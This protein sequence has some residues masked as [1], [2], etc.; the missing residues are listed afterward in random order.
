MSIS[1]RAFLAALGVG[2]V[3]AGAAA[4][5]DAKPASGETPE[6]LG[7]RKQA[8]AAPNPMGVT[9]QSFQRKFGEGLKVVDFPTFVKTQVGVS[10]VSWSGPLMGET[11]A[12]SIAALRA[13]MDDAGVRSVL[14]DPALG[15][16]L[17]SADGV[18]RASVVE[19]L[20][21][22]LDVTRRLSG[23]GVSLD[24]RGEGDMEAQRANALEGLKL[25]LP[26]LKAAGLQG[27]IK[28]LGGFTSHGQFLASLMQTIQDPTI[29]LEPTF[30]SW[31]VS[32]TEEY[33]RVRGIELLM[34][35][36]ACVLADCGEFKPDG[37][38]VNVPT[39][40]LVQRIRAGGFRGPAMMQF[41]GAG[42]ELEGT[43]KIKKLLMRY[44]FRP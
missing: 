22:W 38:P 17:A 21:P 34:P 35:F 43:L 26:V 12:Q 7:A 33:H 6:E 14:V 28:C 1:R 42:D 16:G 4:V 8:A 5:Q 44:P 24:L 30:D 25:A 36:A 23:T 40:Y 37:E 41:K 11:G 9:Q 29:R 2:A 20:K 13:A 39:R 3:A 10:L 27:V 18:A 19:R 31:R 15:A 32:P